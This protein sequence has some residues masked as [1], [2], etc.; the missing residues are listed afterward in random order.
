MSTEVGRLHVTLNADTSKFKEEINT[1]QQR[2][3]DVGGKFQKAGG[4][5][6]KNVTAPILAIGG[7][8]LGMA[9]KYASMGDDIGK[10]STKLGVST[11]ALQ[12]MHYWAGQN[13]IEAGSLDR[14]VGRLNQRVGMAATGNDKYG[15]AFQDL[16]IN[17]HDANGN[18]RDTESVMQDT[19]AALREVEDPA[20][21]SAKASEIF[22]T[23]MARDLMP[24]LEDGSLSLEEATEKIHEM[25]GVM[26]EDAVRNAEKYQDAMDDLKRE[27]GGVFM[28][29][30]TR[31]I[32][33]ITDKLLPAIQDKIIPAVRDFIERIGKLVDWFQN[34][35]PEWQRI[36][37]I[38]GGFLVALGPILIVVGKIISIFSVL[39]PIIKGVGIVF[40]VLTG[41]IG[42]VVAAIAA[43]IAIGV[44]LY[45]NWDEIKAW[46]IEIWGK[47]VEFFQGVWENIT[48]IFS[49]GSEG[50]LSG[51]TEWLG[52][53]WEGITGIFGNILEFY[54]RIWDEIFGIFGT[55]TEEIFG[56]ISEWVSGAW[57]TITEI[58]N[59]VVEFFGNI[60]GAITALFRGDLDEAGT[61]LEK[62]YSGMFSFIEEIWGKIVEFF[63]G[64][65]ESIV[66]LFD[67]E[68]ESILS[69]IGEWLSDIWDSITDIWDNIVD[70]YIGIW[71]EILGLFG[72]STDE[73]FATLKEWLDK[74][75]ENIENIW[76]A[77]TEFFGSIWEAIKALFRGDLEAVGK[78]L[79]EA[80]SGMFEFIQNIWNNIYEFFLQIW[81]NISAG[82]MERANA[83]R[84]GI[85]S[86]IDTALEWI[87]ALPAQALQWG[88]D[89]IQGMIDG[90]RN[91]AGAVGDAIKGVAQGAINSVKGVFG[92]SSPSKV[93]LG[94]GENVSGSLG[95]GITNNASAATGALGA[96]G[97]DLKT[98]AS[99]IASDV[100]KELG[101][102][103][104]PDIKS[105]SKPDTTTPDTEPK[106][107][108]PGHE[109]HTGFMPPWT[110]QDPE[111]VKVYHLY[112]LVKSDY[113][114]ELARIEGAFL[115]G[116]IGVDEGFAKIAEVDKQWNEFISA[117]GGK[118][119]DGG[120]FRAPT[121]G[122]EGLAVLKDGET[123]LPTHKPN[124]NMGGDQ[125]IIIELDGKQLAKTT[126]KYIP[127]QVRL[128]TGMRN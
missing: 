69:G 37:G 29:L 24:A 109:E 71:D 112:R 67:S 28:E 125:T 117:I 64:I 54:I 65:W 76:N 52:K 4:T 104:A 62:A 19:I 101:K 23:K 5:L 45:K 97:N 18:I 26:S 15:E 10:T 90:I 11:D 116:S 73:V 60:W 66:G 124:F 47:I 86:T 113:E 27:F 122:G 53:L 12:E 99:G 50:I 6:T 119:H 107:P 120:V 103:K 36:I 95:Q 81:D 106:P 100:N 108:A 40:A 128:K 48:G 102:I 43:A 127:G 58:W 20:L 38:A 85:I 87:R 63:R 44:A 7:A 3:K 25:G 49:G 35:S 41:P 17:I 61:Y 42:L 84:E 126:G 1:A 39:V 30:G 55:S 115:G 91:M 46:A 68:S 80:Y 22:G 78:H 14:A 2:F 56:V 105:P 70:F 32:P 114:S 94:I 89:I 9:N 111:G 72:T 82:V 79:E 33:I 57:N 21:R 118:Y 88:R 51:I 8:A 75:Q 16:G 93:M 77:I 121:P 74:A 59:N 92:M 13:G 123:V 110:D 96:L 34:L 31:L 83:L 98:Q